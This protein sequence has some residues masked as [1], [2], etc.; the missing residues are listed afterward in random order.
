MRKAE[1][2]LRIFRFPHFIFLFL[3]TTA[4][5][6]W[7]SIICC[8]G[9]RLNFFFKSIDSGQNMPNTNNNMAILQENGENIDIVI[10]NSVVNHKAA[11][12]M[13]YKVGSKAQKF[14]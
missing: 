7:I 1:I 6:N 4:F 5:L 12:T 13:L 9:N 11:L 14:G 2:P 8:V 10:D 3:G